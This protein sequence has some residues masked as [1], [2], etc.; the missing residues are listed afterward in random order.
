MQ[1]KTFFGNYTH[2]L[3]NFL[4]LGYCGCGSLNFIGFAAYF[5]ATPF[6]LESVVGISPIMY[7]WALFV[8]AFGLLLG[9]L[10]NAWLVKKIGRHRTLVVGVFTLTTAGIS[11]LIP[12]LFGIIN[13]TVIVIPMVIF[14]FGSSLTFPQAFAGALHSFKKIAGFAAAL[15]GSFQLV[16]GTIGSGIISI[17]HEKNLSTGQ[18][19]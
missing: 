2:L 14:F 19:N 3:K 1:A 10:I 9:G 11:M 18:K 6:L 12:A 5:T 17:T 7:G 8:I 15:Y 4:F 16:A 13:T